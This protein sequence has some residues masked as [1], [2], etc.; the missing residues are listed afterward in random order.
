MAEN[1][2]YLAQEFKEIT[3]GTPKWVRGEYKIKKGFFK[4]SHI[5]TVAT[6]GGRTYDYD[7]LPETL[8]KSTG[9]RD[10][11]DGLIYE[12]DILSYK[13]GFVIAAWSE[14]A[15]MWA[16]QFFPGEGIGNIPLS[17]YLQEERMEVVSNIYT[18]PD[19][20]ANIG[21]EKFK[22]DPQKYK[23][24]FIGKIIKEAEYFDGI[25]YLYVTDV[26]YTSVSIHD[27]SNT[28][29]NYEFIGVGLYKF[30][31]DKGFYIDREYSVFKFSEDAA[32]LRILGESLVDF[33]QNY[34]TR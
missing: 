32:K 3:S 29:G 10:V 27:G 14:N 9:L 33:I 16:V 22:R 5:I 23:D 2:K 34:E 25:Q 17:Q 18:S 6:A 7:I 24:V 8:H 13:D 1:M 4:D 26:K 15:G 28:A 12:G 11:D 19:F 30:K 20:Y 31:D 21:I